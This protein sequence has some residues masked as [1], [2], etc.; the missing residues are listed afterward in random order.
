MADRLLLA[1]MIAI[2]PPL[3]M[4]WP[5]DLREMWVRIWLELLAMATPDEWPKPFDIRVEVQFS[6]G[7]E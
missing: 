7:G 6:P 1:R 5:K 3:D 4:T 2:F